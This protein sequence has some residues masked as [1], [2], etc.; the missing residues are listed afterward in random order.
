MPPFTPQY[1]N[2][3]QTS[4]WNIMDSK[5]IFEINLKK[6]PEEMNF[7]KSYQMNYSFNSDGYRSQEFVSG[8]GMFLGC[9]FTLAEGVGVDDRWS[10]L[11][12]S[13]LN[14]AENNFGV[15][16]ASGDTCFRLMNY[17]LPKLNP[18]HVFILYPYK[19]RREEFK[20]DKLY[21]LFPKIYNLFPTRY[22]DS[23]IFNIFSKDK[24]VR[25]NYDKDLIEH[26]LNSWLSSDENIEINYIKN[27]MSMQHLCT[28]N[29]TKFVCINVDDINDTLQTMDKARDAMHPGIEAHKYIASLFLEKMSE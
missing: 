16:G 13:S 15:S 14:I 26:H 20:N 6:Y 10:K 21:Q 28:K 23:E 19:H 27:I 17:W 2:A 7:W 5:D 4:N 11:V 3:N 25:D 8:G 9:S 29:N 24:G 12:A 22:S 18:S 1:K